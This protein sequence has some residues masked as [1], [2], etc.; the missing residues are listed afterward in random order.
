MF[1]ILMKKTSKKP[2]ATKKMRREAL[3]LLGQGKHLLDLRAKL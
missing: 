3:L 2:A 1:R